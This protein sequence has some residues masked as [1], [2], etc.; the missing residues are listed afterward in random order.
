MTY[1][2]KISGA[3]KTITAN[4]VKISGTW[5]TISNMWVKIS[6]TWR[7]LFS[8][9]SQIEQTVT[10]SQLTNSSTGLITLTGR[11]YRWSNVSTLTYKFERS[12]NNGVSWVSINSGIATNPA[13][14]SSNTYTY[15]L[16]DNASDV[17][18]N[19]DNLYRFVVTATSSNNSTT[20]STSSNQTVSASRNI[21]NLSVVTANTT[22]SSIKLEFTAGAYSSSYFVRYT[23]EG[24]K[25]GYFRSAGSGIPTT[26]TVTGLSANTNY[27]F[28]VTPYTGSIVSGSNT[29][30]GGNQSSPVFERTSAPPAPTQV[31]SP[32]IS[33]TSPLGQVGTIITGAYGSYTNANSVT[34]SLVAYTAPYTAPTN[35]ETSSAVNN[36]FG[37]L[38][39]TVDQGDAV[40]PARGFYTRDTVLGIN[41]TTY[42]YYSASSISTYIGPITDNFNRSVPSG[43][44]ISSSGYIYSS[45]GYGSWSTNG[46]TASTS[47]SVNFSTVS[48][49]YPLKT[50]ELTGKTNLTAS[51]KIPS[52]GGG[53]GL[54]FW[55]TS[56]GSWWA[57]APSY[58]SEVTTTTTTCSS[59][60][61]SF[62]NTSSC[63]G[64][65]YTTSTGTS[66][67]CTGSVTGSTSCPSPTS[68]AGGRCSATC[69]AVTTTTETC[70]TPTTSSA[71][72]ADNTI[73]TGC[74]Q[75]CSVYGP[76]TQTT[77][78]CTGF[79][80]NYSTL[81]ACNA[82]ATTTTYNASTVGTRCGSCSQP[83][84]GVNLFRAPAVAGTSTTFYYYTNRSCV[85][86]TTYNY[87]SIVETPYTLYSCYTGS[88]SSTATT[89]FSRIR[90]LSTTGSPIYSVVT[91]KDTNIASSTS[92]YNKIYSISVATSGDSI[93][94]KGYNN[95]GIQIGSDVTYSRISS[96]LAK[97]NSDGSS[98][99]G[100]I[101]TPTDTNGG[102]TFDDLSIS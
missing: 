91:N 36:I 90:I 15:T 8:S 70:P 72:K 11:N 43:L 29:G 86:T 84:A 99:A 18:P 73:Y 93:T 47:N 16:V 45:D 26:I 38:T 23:Y 34:T 4:Y 50:I 74:N 71:T 32:T 9:S 27:G 63:N 56:Q 44:G 7:P 30:Y 13:V 5:R 75:P 10:L 92:A 83:I 68:G 64:C 102:S 20:T 82:S 88:T 67:S 35:G 14:G 31:T 24:I 81:A 97:T 57:V 96:D 76:F 60:Y 28:Y 22:S 94:A 101:Y 85:D 55:V 53:P 2:V 100:I 49:N 3:W 6:G 54:A 80:Q 46:S 41:G 19:V 87:S 52:G 1:H 69:T 42:Y 66:S 59:G 61:G 33:G 58:Y 21:S 51:V 40:T 62:S 77:Y 37:S 95:S 78:G 89:Y 25:E 17:Y 65:G 48:Y 98:S 12:A 79:T 39:H